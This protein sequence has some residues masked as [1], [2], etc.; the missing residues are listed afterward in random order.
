MAHIVTNLVAYDQ[1]ISDVEEVLD[2]LIPKEAE[3]ETTS[4]AWFLMRVYPY[5]TLDNV[6]EGAVL[7][8][9]DVTARRAATDALHRSEA[10]FAAA[11]N[12]NPVALS[13]TSK[14]GRFV[15]VNDRF[16]HP[17]RLRV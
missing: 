17:V 2:T 5:R 4:G 1:L 11:F 7:T 13:I 16:P 6:I 3:I 15:A 10:R 8:F 14:D 12:A 9:V